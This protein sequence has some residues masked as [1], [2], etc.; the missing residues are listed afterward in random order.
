ME[1]TSD[2]FPSYSMDDWRKL[3]EKELKGADFEESLVNSKEG[4]RIEPLYDH[5]PEL[6]RDEEDWE[7]G[8]PALSWNLTE[9]YC[10]GEGRDAKAR[11]TEAFNHGVSALEVH[12]DIKGFL[13][14]ITGMPPIPVTLLLRAHHSPVNTDQ[15]NEWKDVVM[16]ASAWHPFIRSLTFDPVSAMASSGKDFEEDN[17]FT[18]LAELHQKLSPYLT[19]AH[20]FHVDASVTGE[21]G[22]TSV[23][24]LA[25]ALGTA[26]S[27]LE[28]MVS[29]GLELFEAAPLISFGFSVR[30]DFFLEIAKLRA[31]TRLWRN[32][33]EAWDEDYSYMEDPFIVASTS[34]VT[35]TV[36]DKHNNL[37][38]ST[39][40]TM[41]SVLGGADAV[42]ARPYVNPPTTHAERMARN[43][44]HLLRHESY[45]DRYASAANGTYFIEEL[46]DQ[47]AG[48][49]WKE[50]GEMEKEGGVISLVRNGK[51]Q[52]KIS[53]MAGDL[54][55][56]YSSGKQV[57]VGVNKYAGEQ[58]DIEVPANKS[59]A[60][61]FPALTPINIEQA[62]KNQSHA[63]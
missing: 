28:A 45:L 56:S 46:A 61:D 30:T 39:T 1:N 59:V 9:V 43:I 15:V 6:I 34:L 40:G 44:H 42:I 20:F 54:I 36:A 29:N 21:A 58:P 4:L 16:A 50:L 53:V 55:A 35:S 48:L 26:N 23:M 31:F 2:G 63:S 3:V 10:H 51:L 38:R 11:I 5:L 7:F 14:D 52:Q 12:G 33:L 8:Q 27:Y 57:L 49:A 17:V 25:Y 18:N 19:D 24:Q 47:L 22:A 32:V 41:A 37:L 62:L 13:K 60:S